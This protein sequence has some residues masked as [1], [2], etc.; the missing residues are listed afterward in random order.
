MLSRFARIT[1]RKY[2][3]ANGRHRCLSASLE[4]Y[5]EHVFR[6]EVAESYLRK[7]GLRKEVLETPE[8]VTDGS[9]DKV[10]I[11]MF[12][13]VFG[14]FVVPNFKFSVAVGGRCCA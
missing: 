10:R 4:G 14:L 3:I 7:H 9:A 12:L 8:W 6:G 13:T 2:S 1:P 5:G 11:A